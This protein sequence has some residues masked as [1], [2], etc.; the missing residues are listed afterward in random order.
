MPEGLTENDVIW[1]QD[2]V[3]EYGVNRQSL[4]R[5]IDDGKLSVI[6]HGV[7]RRVL[8]L[9]AELDRIFGYRVVKPANDSAAG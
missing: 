2:A 3:K 6:T 1:I 4:D 8:L 5:L 9:R 7:S